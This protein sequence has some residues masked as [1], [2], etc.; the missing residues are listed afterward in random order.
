MSC[1]CRTC[2]CTRNSAH[3]C[4]L[5]S[6]LSEIEV[7]QSIYLDELNVTQND[8]GG[9]TVSLVL[10]PSTAED[11]LSQFVRLTL[12][13]DLDSQYPYSYPYISI[14]NP[15]G[16]SDDKLLSLQKSLQMEAEE[17]VGTPVLYQLIE[18]LNHYLVNNIIQFYGFFSHFSASQ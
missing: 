18:V 1:Y 6:V 7:L 13:M 15:R 12:T 16:L 11:C 2:S 3:I 14:H 5:H 4:L 8:E 17:C 10:H 9:W